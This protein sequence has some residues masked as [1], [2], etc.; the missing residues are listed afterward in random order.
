ML[1]LLLFIV[2]ILKC[3]YYHNPPSYNYGGPLISISQLGKEEEYKLLN[4]LEFNRLVCL[5][6][7]HTFLFFYWFLH[8]TRKRMSV[9]IRMPDG[10]IKLL[11]KGAVSCYNHWFIPRPT[12][13]L[14]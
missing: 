14:H 1:L 5:I 6:M 11:C 9:I 3:W 10:T 2:C 7:N 4:L 8:S 13:A 12:I